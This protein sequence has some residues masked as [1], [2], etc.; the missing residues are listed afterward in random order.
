MLQKVDAEQVLSA[1]A[2]VE[3]GKEV[4][5]LTFQFFMWLIS[6]I[7]ITVATGVFLWAK[8]EEKSCLAP[9]SYNDRTWSNQA[10][11]IDVSRRFR[12]VLKIFFACAITDV[13][14]S[15]LMIVAVRRQSGSLATLYQAL[16]I[17]DVLG[18]GA[19]FVL[20]TFRFQLSGKIC[21]GDFRDDASALYPHSGEYLLN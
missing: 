4:G 15:F 20:H 12:D 3:G 9:N 19:I 21:A 5:R 2:R 7:A 16:V 14:R 1:K 17:N 18:F 11:W 6:S 10:N 8:D 13:F